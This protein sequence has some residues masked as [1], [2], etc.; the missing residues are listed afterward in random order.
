M[1]MGVN[2]PTRQLRTKSG[3]S[4]F[5]LGQLGWR[6][7]EI[8]Y[9]RTLVDK[10]RNQEAFSRGAIAILYAHWEG[11]VKIVSSAYLEHVRLQ[12]L[13]LGKLRSNFVALAAAQSAHD[14]A[15]SKR[16]SYQLKFCDFVQGC[17]GKIASWR[18]SF[19]VDTGANLSP[20]RF[21]R[22][23]CSSVYPT[24]KSTKLLRSP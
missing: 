2:L 1:A 19:D 17:D 12:R 15:V 22:S 13:P 7:K 11:L 8:R 10:G 24:A 3:F 16:F 9:Y 21:V 18:R 23:L 4:K 14:A 6:R 5:A 20:E